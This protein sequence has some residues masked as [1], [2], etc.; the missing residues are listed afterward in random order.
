LP[1]GFAVDEMSEPVNLET[2]FGS[3]EAEWRAEDGKL[4]FNRSMKIQNAVV[5]PS[6]YAAVKEFFDQMV[7]AEQSSVVLSRK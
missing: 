7:V 6:D 5:E 3:Y 2:D 1:P 4:Y